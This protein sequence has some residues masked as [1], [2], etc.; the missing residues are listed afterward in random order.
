MNFE[1]SGWRRVLAPLCLALA[2]SL[3]VAGCKSLGIVQSGMPDRQSA[4]A[5][6]AA[7]SFAAYQSEALAHIR[8]S[9]SFQTESPENELAWNGPREWR[10]ATPTRGAGY[11]KGILLVHGLGDSPWT[12]HDIAPELARHGFLVRTL[13]LPGHGTTPR[14]LLNVSVDDWRRVV[15]QQ[16]DAMRADANEIY[17]GGFSTGANLVLEYA[18]SN[19]DIAGLALFSPGFKSMSLDWMV[20]TLARIRPWLRSPDGSDMQSAVRYLT[21][22]TNGLAQYYHSSRRARALLDSAPYD[23]PVFM[24]VAEHDSVLDTAYLAEV[25]DRRFTHPRSRLIW[26]GESPAE[27]RT[28]SRVP[29]RGDRLPEQRISQFSHMGVMF[30]ASNPLYGERGR[31]RVCL[32]GQ[33][34]SDMQACAE[35]AEVWYSDWGY[36]EKGKIHARLTFNPYLSWQNAVMTS[37]LGSQRR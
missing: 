30:A 19:P 25:F 37:V 27:V 17:L 34:K 12:F 36:R 35:G 29:A 10:P 6:A 1:I 14:D 18:Y 9:R 2:F 21:V 26:Y 7:P 23:K 32:N 15:A 28:S 5:S 13:V 20:P 4:S 33:R 22:P 16:A 3:L 8:R 24:V 31:L 11:A